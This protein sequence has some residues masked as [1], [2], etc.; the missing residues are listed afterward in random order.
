MKIGIDSVDTLGFQK[1]SNL[2]VS[3]LAC[4]SIINLLKKT[5]IEK[6][7]VDGLI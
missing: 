3:E 6:Q 4:K 5:R 2:S 1:F 7:E